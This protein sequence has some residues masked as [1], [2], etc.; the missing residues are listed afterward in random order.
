MALFQRPRA[1]RP[2]IG[3]T[4]IAS[5][6][7]I[8]LALSACA[9]STSGGGASST[10]APIRIGFSITETGPD[11]APA[12][13]DLQGYQLG[14]DTIN[15]QGGLLGRKVQLVYYDDQGSASTAVQLYQRLITSDK[16]DLLVGPYQTD[17][18]SA[19]APLVTRYKM[20]MP[21]MA[22]NLEP[23]SGRYPYLVQSITQ[24]PRYM[25]PVIDL[26]ATKGYKT[27]ALLIQDTAFPLELAQGIKQEA[28]ARGIRV[29][30]EATYPADTNDFTALVLKAGAAKPDMIIGAT[31]LADAEGIIRAARAS[32]VN[33]KLF[34]FSIGP[35]EPEFGSAL[36][37]AANGILG[38]TLWFP[39]L[40]TAGNAEFV[41][42]FRAHFG[43]DPDYH[44]AMAYATMQALA[45][46]VRMAGSLDQ[47][48]IRDAYLK[49]DLQT[50]AGEFKLNNL[51]QQ[52]GYQ[53]YVLQ[54]QNGKQEL[55]W[56]PAVATSPVQLPHPNW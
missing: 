5:L 23:F 55:V 14:A 47:T 49:L 13:F 3:H 52:L 6:L 53:A 15:A 32:N 35:V 17:L 18:T 8:A 10:S 2:P 50:V 51:G 19:I 20:A 1:P 41:Q 4:L 39:T 29:V 9:S 12:K 56:P 54:W 37:N 26:A 7:L 21:A 28:A 43:R 25:I 45:A 22:A 44:A 27:L 11:A 31:Y 46:A 33:A 34:A 36:A 48:K 30:F 38:T 16:V 42:N 40:K 24:T